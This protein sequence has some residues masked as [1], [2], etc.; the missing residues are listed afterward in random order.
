MKI[1]TWSNI[2]KEIFFLEKE[3]S[4]IVYAPLL[5]KCF[6]I[7]STEKP[8]VKNFIKNHKRDNDFYQYLYDEN[9]FIKKELPETRIGHKYLPTELFLSLSSACNFAC[10][11]CYA[12][13][14]EKVK[15]L[16]WEEI[17]TAIKQLYIFAQ[18]SRES[19]VEITFHGTG[20]ATVEWDTL[21]KTVSYSLQNLP[22]NLQ[23][24][25]S[26][27]TNGSLLTQER[28]KYLADNNFSITIS[29]DGFE[30]I[31]NKQRPFRN[32][33]KTFDTV[34][35][36]VKQLVKH[37]INFGVRTTI[38]GENQN[39]MIE[40]VEYCS[41]LGCKRIHLVPYSKVG[42]GKTGIQP[43][44]TEKFITD[45]TKLLLKAHNL[46]IK[47]HTIA[48][49]LSRI[50]A[51]FC[52]ADGNIF[53]VMPGGYISSCTRVTQIDDTL[54]G[55][56]FIGEITNKGIHINSK[57]VN[58]LR[59]LNVYNFPDC[60]Y[61]FAKFICSGGCHADRLEGCLS[62]DYCYITR[63]IIFANLLDILRETKQERG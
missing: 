55:T 52:D 31:Q 5:G 43:I 4:S 23:L 27:V 10:T 33:E 54:S 46:D 48:D 44:N 57:K 8:L 62:E 13:A 18:E 41:K 47:V 63:E 56:F 42:R 6:L 26:L 36:G 2:D 45:Y 38:T 14:G 7:E 50:S 28:V 1:L 37:N 51:G 24:Y 49:D 20:E 21:T 29:I 11:Y 12:R 53:A 58:S 32:G 59:H 22:S 61:C 15:K 3:E 40:F 34:I 39:R 16:S 60:K 25:F 9:F 19:E 30:E 17:T 35:A